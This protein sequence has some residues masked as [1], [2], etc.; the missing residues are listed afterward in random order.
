[1]YCPSC[2]VEDAKSSQFCRA[3]GTELSGLRATLEPRPDTNPLG[4]N[5]AREE[6]GRALAD[7]IRQS[8]TAADLRLVIADILPVAERFLETPEEKRLRSEQI[9]LENAQTALRQAR[10]GTVITAIGFAA[11]LIFVVVGMA[12]RDPVW[13]AGG[14]P[15]IV[16]FLIGAGILLNALF[17]TPLPASPTRSDPPKRP[18]EEILWGKKGLATGRQAAL[19]TKKETGPAD[20]S[21]V[22][23]VTEG[24]TRNL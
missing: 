17:F 14:V 13:L 1:M 18:I 22:P 9:G 20:H 4:T 23:S 16:A 5:S 19:P 10:R 21:A 2:G 3:C 6:I 8:E 7:K 24:T 11:A 12:S 15:S